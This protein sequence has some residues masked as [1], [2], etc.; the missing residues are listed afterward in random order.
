VSGSAGVA[1]NVAA[2]PA[3][4]PVKAF[5]SGWNRTA[6]GVFFEPASSYGS[7]TQSGFVCMGIALV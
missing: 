1:V 2:T 4:G 7:T 3:G 6:G 5:P